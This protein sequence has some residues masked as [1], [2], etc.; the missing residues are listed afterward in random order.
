M[1]SSLPL[2]DWMKKVDGESQKYAGKGNRPTSPFSCP[3]NE[4]QGLGT[5]KM[6]TGDQR[7]ALGTCM[8]LWFRI[9][10]KL[11]GK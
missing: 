9:G 5:G 2:S 8:T 7:H 6:R 11:F 1:S 4:I 3:C 10:W